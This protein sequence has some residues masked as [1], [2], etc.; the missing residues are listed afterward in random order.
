MQSSNWDMLYKTV[1]TSIFQCNVYCLMQVYYMY[2]NKVGYTLY[3][4]LG[5]KTLIGWFP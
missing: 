2:V 4:D 5:N 1:S 3:K